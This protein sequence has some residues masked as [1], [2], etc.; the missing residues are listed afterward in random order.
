MVVIGHRKTG[1]AL[2]AK[3]I[4]GHVLPLPQE[5][6]PA[7]LKGAMEIASGIP[8]DKIIMG[9]SDWY[10]RW[11]SD[12]REELSKYLRMLAC[13]LEEMDA[14]LDKW[15]QLQ[16]AATVEISSPASAIWDE[17]KRLTRKVRFAAVSRP[18][19]PQI[20][21]FPGCPGRKGDWGH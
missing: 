3:G 7:L 5:D 18:D 8:G 19:F 1:I 13:P 14:V 20:N 9:A 2:Y 16:L 10:C 11:V 21:A 15:N 6:S 4:R 12:N 17:H